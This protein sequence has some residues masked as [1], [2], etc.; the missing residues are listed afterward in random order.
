M[1]IDRNFLTAELDLLF[2]PGAGLMIVKV[3]CRLIIVSYV[4]HLSNMLSL[5][6]NILFNNGAVFASGSFMIFIII[7]KYYNEDKFK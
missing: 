2:L 4:A 6:S 5:S 3:Y 1:V 7:K